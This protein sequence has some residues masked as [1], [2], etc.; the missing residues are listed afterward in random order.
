MGAGAAQQGGPS[1]GF[2]SDIETIRARARKHI[3]DGAVTQNYDADRA[4]V[5]KLLNEALAT[6][7]VCVLRYRRHHFMA[8]GIH[9]EPIAAEFKV[10]ADEEQQHADRIAARIVQL[11]GE[12]DFSPE[13]LA[14]RS[15]SQY[16][17]ADG[18]TE[19]IKENLIAERIAIE[20]YREMVQYLGERDPTTRRM[21]EE[22]L[23]VEEEHADELAD[24][25]SQE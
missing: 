5:L 6:E 12:P 20:S 24:M 14:A 1:Q 7:L 16:V 4:T 25:L 3:E 23:A 10:H 2:L 8:K 15:H 19:M 11:G 13:G 17:E 22:I 18:L 9:A 21:L